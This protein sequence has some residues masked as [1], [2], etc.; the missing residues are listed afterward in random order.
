MGSMH[1]RAGSKRAGSCVVPCMAYGQQGNF[2]WSLLTANRGHAKKL[3]RRT[4][5]GLREEDLAALPAAGGACRSGAPVPLLPCA[6]L[7]T[8]RGPPE[9]S[10]G[11]RR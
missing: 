5:P 3:G 2:I 8:G 10:R 11:T 7:G 6:S 4:G 9:R 1:E